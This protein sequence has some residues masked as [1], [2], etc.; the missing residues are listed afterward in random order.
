MLE[1]ELEL[2]RA[3]KAAGRKDF[4]NALRRCAALV[5]RLPAD[6]H[7]AI[8]RGGLSDYGTRAIG[9]VQALLLGHVHQ[10]QQ[11]HDVSNQRNHGVISSRVARRAVN[12]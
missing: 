7:E 4:L 5:N 6:L 8:G 2:E 10:S 12:V 11:S 9:A 1:L 3:R